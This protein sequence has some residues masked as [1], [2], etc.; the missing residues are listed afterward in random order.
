MILATTQGNDFAFPLHSETSI[1]QGG[2]TKREY[3]A[4]QIVAGLLS[5]PNGRSNDIAED[6]VNLADSLIKEL[7]KQPPTMPS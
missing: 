7:N 5:N 2:L 4:S 1:N 6:A 3:F